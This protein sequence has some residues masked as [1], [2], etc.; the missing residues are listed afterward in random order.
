MKFSD[1]IFEN[2]IFSLPTHSYH[3]KRS[4]NNQKVNMKDYDFNCITVETN[5]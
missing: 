2:E 3:V 1:N 4:R 5:A